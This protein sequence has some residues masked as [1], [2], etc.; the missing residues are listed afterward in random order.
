MRGEKDM[1]LVNTPPEHA[2]ST[3]ITVNYVTWRICQDP[4]I[5]ILIV[6]KTQEM[7][8]RFL[9]SVKDRLAESDAFHE[10]QTRFGPPGGFAEGSS[11]WSADKI[12]VG[13][14]EGG[15][16]DPTVLA[17]G[18]RGHVYGLRTDLGHP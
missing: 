6:S 2:K 17:L 11:S 5:R 12:Y 13:T 15:E 10:L 8:K 7:A 18:I 4:N 1:I 9:L 14:R 3:T 16:K